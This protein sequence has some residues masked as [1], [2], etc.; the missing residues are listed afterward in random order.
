MSFLEDEPETEALPPEDEPETEALPP[1]SEPE[2]G[3]LDSPTDE[4]AAQPSLESPSPPPPGSGGSRTLD[5]S[6]TRGITTLLISVAA[7]VLLVGIYVAAGGLDYKPT[8]TSDP[9]NS[10]V[11]ADT[12]NLEE[13]T[14]QFAFSAIDGAACELGVSRE[15]LTRALASDASRTQFAEE[16]G[17]S[18]SQ[19]E[20]AFRSGLKRAV[21]DAQNAN[22]LSPLAATA[23]RAA[24]SVAPM[25]VL[26][27]LI[28]NSEQIFSGGLGGIKSFGDALGAIS[29]A[30]TGADSGS[31]SNPGAGT[32]GSGGFDG[33][34][35]GIIPKDLQD[36]IDKQLP[37]GTREDLQN[38]AEE[39]LKKGLDS[40]LN[41]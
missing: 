39:Q 40:L 34:L 15:E 32:T 37:D 18:D 36:Q 21:D 23:A 3:R 20:D 35:D 28:D 12:N 17:L 30:I 7:S 33:V 8:G 10:R 1:E 29:D 9:C 14:Q 31:G 2:T 11:W 16:N 5:P 27:D 25:S 38:Q 24:I 4:T 26:I 19:I 22:A 13:A 41:P 6:N